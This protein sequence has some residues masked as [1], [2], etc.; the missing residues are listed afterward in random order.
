M[1]TR[2][3]ELPT[4]FIMPIAVDRDET[5]RLITATVTGQLT[6]DDLFE[7]MKTHWATAGA[8]HG[9][10]FD[11]RE[12]IVDQTANDIRVLVSR[13]ERH[14][15]ALQAPFAM[16]VSEDHAFGL[17]RMYEVLL[18]TIGVLRTR[19]FRSMAEA[20]SWLGTQSR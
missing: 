18:Q 2:S 13:L 4:G 6:V 14:H 17:A 8:D 20:E 12:M 7:F 16:V 3:C 15:A 5:R 10:V 11:A 9:I 1:T 19:A